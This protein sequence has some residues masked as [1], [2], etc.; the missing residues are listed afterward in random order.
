M[1]WS[2]KSRGRGIEWPNFVETPKKW[3][4]KYRVI[5]IKEFGVFGYGIV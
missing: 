2:S 1:L 3:V 5:R 4:E